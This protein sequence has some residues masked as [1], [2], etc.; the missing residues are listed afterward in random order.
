MQG[1]GV[2]WEKLLSDLLH[3]APYT[4]LFVTSARKED[5]VP[6]LKYSWPF[7]QPSSLYKALLD[8][9]MSPMMA[10]LSFP[11]QNQQMCLFSL[12]RPE[13]QVKR[14]IGLPSM[15]LSFLDS[16]QT[17]QLA[18]SVSHGIPSKLPLL[19]SGS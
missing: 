5:F 17:P 6:M 12:Q 16:I 14:D 13:V 3:M 18:S 19:P 8:D 15:L 1:V 2:C 9:S 10:F 7:G 4:L 11:P